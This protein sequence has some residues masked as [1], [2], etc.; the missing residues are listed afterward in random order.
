MGQL[1]SGMACLACD[2]LPMI[3]SHQSMSIVR[4]IVIGYHCNCLDGQFN[5]QASAI[6]LISRATI[7]QLCD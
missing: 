2:W 6:W 7:Y 1:D 4:L 3:G 5:Y